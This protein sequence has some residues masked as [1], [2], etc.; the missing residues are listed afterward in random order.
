MRAEVIA[1]GDE[2]T[3]G[4]R[5]DTNSQWISQQLGDMG[6]DVAFHTTVG[7][8][9]DD[10]L[11]VLRAA[12]VRAEIVTITGGLGPTADDLTRDALA[13]TVGVELER[14]EAVVQHI[15]QL[16]ESRGRTMPERNAVQADFPVGSIQIP[17]PHGT[18][19]GI[20]MHVEGGSGKC[21]VFALPGVPAEMH[22]M[23]QATVAPVIAKL[24]PEP[25]V[26]RHRSI[27]CFGIGESQLEAMLPDLVARGRIP[28]VGITASDATIT[29]RIT[30][31][32]RDEQECLL[33]ME[34]TAA[35]IYEKLGQ[36]IYGEDT[37]GLEHVVIRLLE[38]RNQTLAIAEWATE[39]LI[40]RWLEEASEGNQTYLG[41][42]AIGSKQDVQQLAGMN[43][44]PADFEPDSAATA[45]MLAE[46][47][48]EE[49]G[50]DF[51][52]GVAAYPVYTENPD[53]HL[54]VSVATAEQTHQLRFGCASHPAIKLARSAKQALNA[55]RLH[56][57]KDP[58]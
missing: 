14:D 9:L 47:V 57:L 40:E 56:L 46:A 44:L 55:L 13:K 37:E 10:N 34:P 31:S 32:G 18:A 25:R 39:G 23:W 4:Q 52:L 49:Y 53:S 42:R 6:I 22:E 5:L 7:D 41:S 58:V 27:R 48:R 51:G 26:T 35:I 38:E 33:A 1:I 30:A 45:K 43:A 28:R 17:N 16:F 36:L 12:I 24:Q 21:A 20:E 29:L 8:D 15:R 2:L 50:S 19:P 54:H 3:S 11:A